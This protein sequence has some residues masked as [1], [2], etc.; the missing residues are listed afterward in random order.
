MLDNEQLITFS[1]I[2]HDR[3]TLLLSISRY[4]GLV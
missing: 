1:K 4:V 3:N 2:K